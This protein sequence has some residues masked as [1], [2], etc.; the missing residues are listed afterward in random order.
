MIG[1][2]DDERK[3]IQDKK[4]TQYQPFQGVLSLI[5][6][7]HHLDIVFISRK[8]VMLRPKFTP[9]RLSKKDTL[10]DIVP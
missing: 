2:T 6:G 3:N 7:G 4:T 8:E 10:H 5:S 9:V 1:A